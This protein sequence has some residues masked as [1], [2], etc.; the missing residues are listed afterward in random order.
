MISRLLWL[1]AL[2]TVLCIAQTDRGQIRG[3]VTDSQGLPIPGV[4]VVLLNTSTGVRA[5]SASAGTGDFAFP[6]LVAGAYQVSAKLQ[7]FKEFTQTG[8]SVDVGRTVSISVALQPGELTETVTVQATA[9]LLDSQTSDIGTSVTRRQILDLP[10]PLSGDS[11]NPLAFVIL[12]PGVAGS[13]PGATPDLRLHV[14]GAPSASS[15]VYI[16][17]IPVSDT[18][19]QGD[20]SANHPSIEAIGEFKIS[21]NSHSAEYGL[22]SGIVSFTFQSGTNRLHGSLFEFL[23]NDKLNALDFPTKAAGGSK[24]PLKQNEYGFTVGGPVRIPK[25]YNG[26]DHTFFFA[27]YTGFKF[28]PSSNNPNLTTFPNR[29]RTGDFSQLLAAQ[30]TAP[31]PLNPS[32]RLPI[33]DA[34]GR[35]VLQ[36][37]IYDPTTSRTVTGPDGNLYPVRDPF[38]GNV[39]PAS[40]PGL[41]P[42]AKKILA[43]FPQ[44]TTDA[45]FNNFRRQT[46]SQVNQD[47]FVAKIDHNF[48]NS[49][50][51][52]G[53]IFLGTNV[54]SNIGAL[55]LLSATQVDTPTTQVRLSHNVTLSPTVVNNLSFGFLRDTAKNGPVQPGPSLQELGLKGISLTP[56]APFPVIGIRN[57]NGIGTGVNSSSAQDRFIVTDGLNWT[58]GSHSFKF[59]GEMRRLQRNERA[60]NGGSFSFEPLQTSLGGTGFVNTS[61]DPKAVAIPAGTGSAQASFLFG[62]PDFSRFDLGFTTEGYRWWIGSGYVQDDWKVS[63]TNV[64]PPGAGCPRSGLGPEVSAQVASQ[65]CLILCSGRDQFSGTALALAG[66]AVPS[67]LVVVGREK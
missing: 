48:W 43:N 40:Y 15:E 21:N 35:P 45:I 66:L 39:I 52:S 38:P 42:S 31:N 28:R 4:N 50:H 27:S 41:S 12:T 20:I 55:S 57:Q 8:I 7:G 30:L 53:S 18:A 59:G 63:R 64:K 14:S 22:A 16:D 17:G 13:I 54:N 60:N 3:T 62:A 10:V 65:R 26:K 34:A 44:A 23:Q 6:G 46:R 49:H 61:A 36:G 2:V 11:R 56:G 47:R 37:G 33:V 29:F 51:L 24:A 19:S 25:I 1:P 32:E 67:N 9:P 58:R 5:E